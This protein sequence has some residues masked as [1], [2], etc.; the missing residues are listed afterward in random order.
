VGLL[1]SGGSVYGPSAGA[2]IDMKSS[3]F[4]KHHS[5]GSHHKAVTEAATLLEAKSGQS[6]DSG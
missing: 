5:R 6:A 1:G 4:S 3:G 2:G